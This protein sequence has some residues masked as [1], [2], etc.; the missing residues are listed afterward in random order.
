[1]N[2]IHRVCIALFA[3]L[4]A[5]LALVGCQKD[6]FP[7]NKLNA[8]NALRSFD[9]AS[10]FSNGFLNSFR[11]RLGGSYYT[12]ADIQSDLL[13]PAADFGNRRGEVADWTFRSD[14][15]SMSSIYQGYYGALVDINYYIEHCAEITLNPLEKPKILGRQDSTLHEY[16]ADAHFLRAFY[17]HELALRYSNTYHPEELCVPLVQKFD[18]LAKTPRATQKQVFDF[19]LSELDLAQ[20]E[21][22]AAGYGPSTY[23]VSA[24]WITPDAITALRARVCLTMGNYP[25][26]SK[27]ALAVMASNAGYA[28]ERDAENFQ[29]MWHE[30]ERNAEFLM[31]LAA[32]K[33]DEKPN[34]MG[35]I[36]GSYDASTDSY[37]PDFI[38][39]E[40]L[41]KLYDQTK[42]IRFKVFFRQ[43][44]VRLQ[45]GKTMPNVW[46]CGKFPGAGDL[47]QSGKTQVA[48]NRPKPLRLAEMY[49]IAAEAFF[50][51][52]QT[53]DAL[54]YL[55]D[56]RTARGLDELTA[57]TLKDIQDERLREMVFEG[58]RLWDL[59]RWNMPVVREKTTSNV[60]SAGYRD[61][62]ERP[63]GDYRFVWPIPNNDV[64]IDGVQQ[65][66][67]Y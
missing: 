21:M 12:T 66:P 54:A 37:T 1:M 30:D 45:G 9:D 50:Q 17:Y 10:R 58:T 27:A 51:N 29:Y 44:P 42:D 33:D 31:M 46:I 60:I 3:L 65:N 63:A 26:A 40:E 14:A 32:N 48:Y 47:N 39:T 64:I 19:I 36:A 57:V 5:G 41:L 35:S 49:L 2:R 62:F 67:G 55:N 53:A 18:I 25:E 38:P 16:L 20:K 24:S 4:A 13:R 28:L 11:Y 8:N 56:L 22:K 34:S 7:T 61:R 59:R 43:V 52:G 23:D 6:L 15:G